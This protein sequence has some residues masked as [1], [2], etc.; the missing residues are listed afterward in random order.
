MENHALFI[1][2]KGGRWGISLAA[3]LAAVSGALVHRPAADGRTAA[4]FLGVVL[5]ALAC[6]WGN[7]VQERRRDALMR[8]TANRPLV[9]GLVSVRAAL[10]WGG[11]CLCASLPLLYACGG[12]MAVGLS[13]AAVFLY[14]G[15]Y[16]RWKAQSPFALLAGA[17]AGAA[18]PVLGWVCAGGLLLHWAPVVLFLLFLFWQVPHF[19]LAA[20]RLSPDYENA[21]FSVPWLTCRSYAWLLFLWLAAYG[22]MLLAL[23]ALGLVRSDGARAA[24]LG[25][26]VFPLAGLCRPTL[27]PR[28][29]FRIVNLSMAAACVT[30]AAEGLCGG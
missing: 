2:V 21:G 27:R 14:N 15:V 16:T 22:V 24:I 23:P 20:E 3:G 26:A 13:L 11:L 10:C 9:K 25:A 4:A 5:V 8:R 1:L 19:W 6:T 29:L 28:G 18:P 17:S 30:L 12:W 7:Q